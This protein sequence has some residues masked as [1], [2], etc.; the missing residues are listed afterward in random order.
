MCQRILGLTLCRKKKSHLIFETCGAR[1]EQKRLPK[2]LK[3]AIHI[4][5]GFESKSALN[6]A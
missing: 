2:R 6:P 4:A 5:R 1:I 3:S